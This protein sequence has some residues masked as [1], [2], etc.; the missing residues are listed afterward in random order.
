[1][2]THVQT[3]I[4]VLAGDT[5]RFSRLGQVFMFAG[6]EAGNKSDVA[7]LAGGVGKRGRAIAL[8]VAE[9]VTS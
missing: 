9:Q 6:G 2:T 7:E 5:K 1:M 4:V 8:V 3:S